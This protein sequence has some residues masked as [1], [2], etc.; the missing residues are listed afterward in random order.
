VDTVASD[1]ASLDLSSA[2]EAAIRAIV[3][4]GLAVIGQT[5]TTV[6]SS[7]DQPLTI[8]CADDHTLVGD[9]VVKVFSTAGY[10]VER[11]SDGEE[12]WQKLAANLQKFD[13]VITDHDMP[14]ANGLQLVRRL[15]DAKYAGRI[16][17]HSSGLSDAD[18][19]IYR[20]MGVEKV[21]MKS[22]DAAKLLGIVKAL[23]RQE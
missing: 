16:I 20:E 9:A 15:R 7:A 18:A 1:V 4:A 13:V 23:H 10:T 11:A 14:R 19:A 2:I 12:A 22:P 3:A 6:T 17:V 8:L 5:R 21:V